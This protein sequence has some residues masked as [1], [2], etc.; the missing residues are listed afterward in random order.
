[1]VTI[2]IFVEGGAVR[3]PNLNKKCRQGFRDFFQKLNI[4][5]HL[6][7]AVCGSRQN[8][9]RDFRNQMKL[10]KPNEF[11]ILLVDSEAPVTNPADKATVWEHVSSRQG[12]THWEKPS[13]ATDDNLH[14]MVECMENWFMADKKALADYY[15]KDFNQN[16]LSKHAKIESISKKELLDSLEKATQN[17]IKGEYNKGSHSFE[18]LSKI[19][20]NKVVEQS[21][22]AS[23]LYKTLHKLQNPK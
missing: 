11:C 16:A 3:N 20:A 12:D 1:M 6:V 23:R 15:G 19:D 22:Y 21:P 10:N 9:H 4:K 7:I 13:N 5:L 18:I 17:T 8:A 2:K 14:F